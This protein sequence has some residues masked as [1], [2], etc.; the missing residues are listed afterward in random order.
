MARTRRDEVGC[1]SHATKERPR[2]HYSRRGSPAATSSG[3]PTSTPWGR[4]RKRN[5]AI[6]FFGRYN[7]RFGG[8]FLTRGFGPTTWGGRWW[9]LLCRKKGSA[10]AW[11]S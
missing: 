4:G 9:M 6:A 5:L 2:R 3:P 1:P 10:E 7:L 11:F 8:C